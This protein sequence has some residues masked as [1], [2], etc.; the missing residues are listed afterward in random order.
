[1]IRIS[2]EGMTCNHC[3]SAVRRALLESA[4]IASAEVD[5]KRGEAVVAGNDFDDAQLT[6]A[7]ES[8]GYRVKEIR[9]AERSG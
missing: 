3:A 5:L 6:R 1:M 2:I 7:V 9:E 4:G 8:L